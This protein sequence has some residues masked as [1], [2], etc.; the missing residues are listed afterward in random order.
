MHAINEGGIGFFLSLSAA[1]EIT[2]AT[3]PQY[4]R[5]TSGTNTPHS[6]IKSRT[7]CSGKHILIKVEHPPTVGT[8]I[9]H[10][11]TVTAESHRGH[12]TPTRSTL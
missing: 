6:I 9:T 2:E 7:Q 3:S 1:M 12:A 10:Q 5:L 4:E 8:G 11:H